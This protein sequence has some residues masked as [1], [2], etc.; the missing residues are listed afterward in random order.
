ML[1]TRYRVVRAEEYAAML[2][3]AGH[4]APGVRTGAAWVLCSI[5]CTDPAALEALRRRAAVEDDP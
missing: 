4:R 3:L 2:P 5:R 1:A